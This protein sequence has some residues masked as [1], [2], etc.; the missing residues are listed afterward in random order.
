MPSIF[1]RNGKKGFTLIEL[2]VVIA[3]ISIITGV[4]WANFRYFGRVF[5]V[6]RDIGRMAQEIRASL[7]TTMAMEHYDIPPDC[8][9]ENRVVAYGVNFRVGDGFYNKMIYIIDGNEASPGFGSIVCPEV[10]NVVNLEDGSIS[11]IEVFF[12][13]SSTSVSELDIIFVPPHPRTYIGG[14]DVYP[15]GDGIK[16]RSEYD[17]AEISMSLAETEDARTV[18][19]NRVGLIEIIQPGL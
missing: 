5:D 8:T 14:I 3:M 11:L 10:I 12:G 15:V 18:K 19:V 6:E 1:K 7:E 2:M 17:E 16:W 13:V 9:G 4:T